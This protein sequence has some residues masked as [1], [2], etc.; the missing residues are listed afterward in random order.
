[1]DLH[2]VAD[3]NLKDVLLKLINYVILEDEMKIRISLYLLLSLSTVIT[4]CRTPAER[5][6][7]P[8]YDN[9]LPPGQYALRKITDPSLLPDFTMASLDLNEL[10]STVQK[11]L[12]YLSK[13]SSQLFFP[14]GE[15]SHQQAVDSLRAFSDLLASGLSGPE[16]N[17]AIRQNFDVYMSVGC[18]DHGTVL[19]TGYYSPILEGSFDPDD[20]FKYPLYKQPENLIKNSKGEILGRRFRDGTIGPYPERAVIEDAMMLRN[21]EL[22]WLKDPFEV[23]IAH[24]QGSAKIKLPDGTL[25]TVGYAANNGHEYK[26]IVKELV[27]NGGIDSSHMSLSAMINYFKKNPDQ[28]KWYTRMNPRF[29]FFRKENGEP[30]GSLNEPVTPMRTIATDKSIFPRGCLS[31]I[32]TNLPQLRGT[33]VLTQPY[34]GFVLDQDTGG[35]IRAPGRCDIYMG[36][37]DTAGELAGRTYQE[38]KLYYLFLKSTDYLAK[39]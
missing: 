6:S 12:N 22:V 20:R 4:G 27:N 14:A 15:I 32:S 38:G 9:P 31:F 36:Q 29:V 21:K 18:D 37:G 11:S 23:Y 39:S 2:C 7:K 16:L 25:T 17:A 1:M 33:S 26:S 5:V 24:V 28:V 19:F 34:T 30:R 3:K 13:P 8:P 10:N 35:A